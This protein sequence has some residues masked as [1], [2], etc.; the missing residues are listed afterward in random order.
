MSIYT[1]KGFEGR[2][3]YLTCV[4]DTYELPLDTVEAMADMLGAEEDFD[5]LLSMCADAAGTVFMSVER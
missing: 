1:D 4:A 5:G 3:D 2:G